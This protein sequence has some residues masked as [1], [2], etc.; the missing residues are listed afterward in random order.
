MLVKLEFLIRLTQI[1]IVSHAKITRV[2]NAGFQ[3]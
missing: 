1:V 2:A 3:V